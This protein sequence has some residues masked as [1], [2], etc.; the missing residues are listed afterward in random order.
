MPRAETTSLDLADVLVG[1]GVPFRE[2]HAIVGRVVRKLEDEGRAFAAVTD[3]DLAAVD[4]RFQPGDA[5]VADPAESVRRRRVAERV[6]SQV[7]RI[8]ERLG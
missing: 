5:A 7:A 1:R 8:R 4:A 2:A 3:D 6:A